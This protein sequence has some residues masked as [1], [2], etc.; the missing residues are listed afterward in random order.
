MSLLDAV[1]GAVSKNSQ[2][3]SGLEDLVGMVSN[4]PQLLQ[5][6]T[7]LLGNDGGAGGLQGLVAKFQQAGMGDVIAS[8]IGT[9]QNQAISGEQLGNVLGNDSL[10]GLASQLGVST[11]DVAGQLSGILPGLVDKLTPSGQPPA[12]GLGNVDD[13]MGTLGAVFKG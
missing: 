3:S 7:N 6:A 11:G 5:I 13:L 9:G 10:S 12:G 8:W 1:L 2:G 4:N